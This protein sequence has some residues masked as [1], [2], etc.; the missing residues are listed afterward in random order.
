MVGEN[1][2]VELDYQ[3][4][5]VIDPNKTIDDQG[6]VSERAIKQEDLVMYAD[7]QCTLYP[8]TRLAVGVNGTN[9]TVNV[10]LSKISFV[11]PGGRQFVTN[12][13]YDEFTGGITQN[14]QRYN[15][16][17]QSD[18]EVVKS[19]GT[20]EYY[21]KQDVENEY[22]TGL[23][24]ITSIAVTT[25]FGG[26]SV[27][28]IPKVVINLVDVR[29][30]ALFEK[31]EQSPYAAFYN[32]PSPIF[33]LTLK[34]YLGKALK[35]RL[36]LH[37]FNVRYNGDSGNFDITLE[38][39][40]DKFLILNK[41]NMGYVR[42]LPYM[43]DRSYQITPSIVNGTQLL[44]PLELTSPSRTN[45]SSLLDLKN[46]R[47]TKGKQKI[48][49]VYNEYKNKGLISEDFPEITLEQFQKRLERVI[50]NLEQSFGQQQVG[51]LSDAQKYRDL[52]QQYQKE[53]YFETNSWFNK[54]MD[55]TSYFILKSPIPTIGKTTRIYTF[56]PQG[57]LSKIDE[58]KGI[59]KKYEEALGK[60]ETFG[61][62]IGFYEVEGK[63]YF[64]SVPNVTSYNDFP[65]TIQNNSPQDSIDFKETYIQRFKK[66]PNQE[67]LDKFT[68]QVINEFTFRG[69][70]V[71][72]GQPVKYWFKFEGGLATF[73]EK[74]NLM[75]NLLANQEKEMNER[76][77][78]A[79]NKILSDR[80]VG[81]GFEPSIRNMVAIFVANTE[82]FVR[83][84]N[85][86]HVLA[87][88][89]RESDVRRDAILGNGKASLSSDGKNVVLGE[90]ENSIIYPWPQY[91][92]Q[93]NS[94]NEP[95]KE[96]YPG[97]PI[98]IDQ[99]KGYLY[100]EWP[101]VEFVEEFIKGRAQTKTPTEDLGEIVNSGQISNKFSLNS[102]DF[103]TTS[104][105]VNKQAV[106]FIYE[107]WERTYLAAYYQRFNKDT[108]LTKG[109]YDAIGSVEFLNIL[110]SLGDDNP[111]LIRTLKNYGF[112]ATNIVPY[113]A[114]I[115]NSGKGESWQE[116]SRGYFTTTY[117]KNE[118]KNTFKIYDESY[119]NGAIRVY[120]KTP[121]ELTKVVDL[122]SGDTSNFD[123]LD[124]YPFNTRTWF[125]SGL[126]NGVTTNYKDSFKTSKTL[127]LNQ[128]LKQITN[129]NKETSKSDI[130][131]VTNF[132]YDSVTLPDNTIGTKVYYD[133]KKLSN[134]I[135]T[136]GFVNYG[137]GYIG[138]VKALQTTS[139]MNTPYFVNAIQSGVNK[140]LFEFEKYPFVS[141]AYLFLNSLPL[142]TLREKYKTKGSS[143]ELDY[144]FAS[145]KKFG[146]LHKLPYAWIL[147]YGSIW[148]RYKKYQ[149]ENID[150]LDG[151]W[152]NF[153][154]VGNFDPST[155]STINKEY[156]IPLMDPKIGKFDTNTISTITLQN[157]I[158]DITTGNVSS[159]MNL[160]F[161]PKLINDFSSFYSGYRVFSAYTET[162]FSSRLNSGYT[163]TQNLG[164]SILKSNGIDKLNLKRSLNLRTWVVTLY[165]EYNQINYLAPSFG[166]SYNQV[167]YECFNGNSLSLEV[168]GNT[169]IFNGSVR[170]L[171]G[172]SNFGYFDNSSVVRPTPNQYM[173]VIYTGQSEQS[174]F[175][176]EPTLT[177]TTIEELFGVF[178]KEQLDVFETE[179][180]NFCKPA[181]QYETTKAT[182][183]EILRTIAL[184]LPNDIET[185][186]RNFQI[187]MRNLMKIDELPNYLNSENFTNQIINKQLTNFV[188]SVKKFVEFDVV[189]KNGNPGNFDRRLFDSFSTKYFIEDPITFNYY[190]DGNLPGVGQTNVTLASSKLS[191]PNTWK[192][193][194]EYVGFSSISGLS[195]NDKGSYITDFFIDNN[196][197][198]IPE[199][200]ETLA[201]L[202]KIYA[203]KKLVDPTYNRT[204]FLNDIDA[205]LDSTNSFQSNVINSICI[206][207]NKDLP[208]VSEVRINT[209][210]PEL[211]GTQTKLS[212]YGD[213]KLL[214]DEW[215]SGN[216]YSIQTLFEDYMFVDRAGRDIGNKIYFDPYEVSN[217]IKS[218]QDSNSIYVILNNLMAKFKCPCMSY[219]AY[220][221]FY[222]VQ[223]VQKNM[224][225]KA[226]GSIEFANSL[227]G[228]FLNV[229]YRESSPKIVCTFVNQ[230]S[231][232]LDA[233]DNRNYIFNSDSFDLRRYS[234]SPL[235][236][237]LV[238]K[239]DW[240]QTN[241]VVGFSLD[242]GIRNQ[243]VF[244]KFDI[245]SEKGEPTSASIDNLTDMIL[246]ANGKGSST[247]NVSLYNYYKNQ[248]YTCSVTMLGNAMIQPGMYFN[249]RHVP[250]FN[251]AYMI[252]NVSHNI[253]P[254]DFYT[255]F[256]A[257]RQPIHSLPIPDQY[258]QSL[259]IKIKE[260]I[261][262]KKK[263]QP[264]N[265][266]SSQSSNVTNSN[267]GTQNSNSS[268]QTITNIRNCTDLLNPVYTNYTQGTQSATTTSVETLVNTIKNLTTDKN[269]RLI[270]FVTCYMY[271]FSNSQFSSFNN[272]FCGASLDYQWTGSLSDFLKKEYLCVATKNNENIPYATFNSVE[273]CLNLVVAKWQPLSRTL[274]SI[275]ENI[276]KEWFTSWSRTKLS[277]SDFTS[278]VTNNQTSYDDKLVMVNKA[279]ALATN[280][281][282]L[283]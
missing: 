73:V 237:N 166:S 103:P 59:I 182:D 154:Y 281:G 82:A 169:S 179:F 89:K 52:I 270:S 141:A 66:Q 43:Y 110:L 109:V 227:F 273:N 112:N 15:Q 209:A 278:F 151:V 218:S 64:S 205:Y 197:E 26:S 41:I 25:Q 99:T 152:T 213:F 128:E 148:H 258:V 217:A 104:F 252:Q 5:I 72:D 233:K 62:L 39:Y 186:F 204:K 158:T 81:L 55:K 86:V 269:V 178:S 8:R 98:L 126:A 18:K 192:K 173:K 22:D 191:N 117:I 146:G 174:A 69:V 183:T 115:S 74:T 149:T 268:D 175:S 172:G 92:V 95:F 19:D 170:M 84:I 246:R 153:D 226:E 243:N 124:T 206:K 208:N 21:Y 11:S 199:S 47:V 271:S 14:G 220:M 101:E 168:T 106:K 241:K 225:P 28:G 134:L 244:M 176:I 114:H 250:L 80:T 181:I 122:L 60:N 190:V 34:G 83:L 135:P 53:V 12:D 266:V 91:F 42:S 274:T 40:A 130:R 257:I 256:K 111:Y 68:Q 108:S 31:G 10:P 94:D 90:S 61:K 161:Y 184:K 13:Y 249:L 253:T 27:G 56:N 36:Y 189:L 228:T 142:A 156:N 214:N 51:S 242:V 247:Q 116:Y 282:L 165:D 207:I 194:Y 245:G 164:S 58:L 102:V 77:Q 279:I 133:N 113:M 136:E 30:R 219:P 221:N 70:E 212:L 177:Y 123:F 138:N 38:L 143:N 75:L 171:W 167:N 261:E 44:N 232:H 33:E 262:N 29:G 127:F 162:E 2:F 277:N 223:E 129:F 238:N 45:P 85:D 160:G 46:V 187:L 234:D 6:K 211:D 125:V 235:L 48:K 231:K 280:S 145:L 240:G 188:D 88:N 67:E 248:H 100:D 147:K 79:I 9:Q 150:I 200:V 163:M 120:E 198:F 37:A 229:D 137:S 215:I 132:N 16:I 230:P 87:W 24:G 201:P 107:L 180:L 144:I 276:L 263:Q 49:E 265:I 283:L 71:N 185:G 76:I 97:D 32:M 140:W 63:K 216:D 254:G 264:N 4:I 65:V 222:N 121:P 139:I 35:Y 118:L 202:V 195:Y 275:P 50:Q 196:I 3:N 157:N 23:M 57:N 155:A 193:L 272:N 259:I 131:P 105:Y 267:S 236:E 7:L 96:R 20:R 17:T 260:N 203:T 251:G 54:Y 1:I 119:I 224:T 93:D 159:T 255:T 78:K 210:T 239:N